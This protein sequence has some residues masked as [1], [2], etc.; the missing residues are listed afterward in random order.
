MEDDDKPA[1]TRATRETPENY[2]VTV[3][4]TKAL[5]IDRDTKTKKG[6]MREMTLAMAR[7]L[8]RKEIAAWADPRPDLK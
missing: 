2:T 5:Q 8:V 1:R 4:M 6:E 7:D 3:R